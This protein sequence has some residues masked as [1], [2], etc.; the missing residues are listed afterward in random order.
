M[1]DL[2]VSFALHEAQQEIH[3]AAARFAVVVAGRRF[4]KTTYAIIRGIIEGLL[5]TNARGVALADDSE[6]LYIGTTLEQA[7]RNAWNLL[8]KY[9]D[10]VIR[11]DSAGRKMIFE[12]QS[13]V[14][15]VTGVRIRLLG[16]DNPD[17]ARGMKI[18]FAI[19]D[20]Y[21]Q[22]PETVW[23]EII[24]PALM[25]TQGGA[26]FIGTP[27]GRN[28][29]FKLFH[30]VKKGLRG[31]EWAAFNY[32]SF[33]NTFMSRKEVESAA[34]ELTRGTPHLMAQEIEAK[35][36]EP[37]GEIFNPG[38]FPI[39]EDEP[40]SG[41]YHIAVDLAGFIESREG[42]TQRD[43]SAIAVV[44]VFPL[45]GRRSNSFLSHGWWVRD[46]I[47]GQWDV[48]TTA[49]N[50]LQAAVKYQVQ[51]VGIESGALKNAVSGYLNE[52]IRDFNRPLHLEDLHHNNRSKHDR[53][54]WA[55]EGRA[56]KGRIFLAPGDWNEEFIAQACG[57]PSRLVHDDLID[58]V[59]YIDQM[60]TN[61]MYDVEALES[62]RFEPMDDASGY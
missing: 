61:T 15:L 54:R 58:A 1:S 40:T 28:H 9:A 11:L 14:V 13:Y 60:A 50:I 6:V 27:K 53:V 62:I 44:K 46:I 7:R 41:S 3:N 5:E 57:F 18:R 38:M 16:M 42:I 52:Y 2:R 25:D 36:T 51:R 55:L 43:E 20:E 22:M 49:F 47:H 39:R 12:N 48:R 17:S 19:L 32:S 24:R 8:K 31:P 29:F 10:P 33:A 59:A 26:L 4:G 34:I 37:G 21:A 23:P 30:E 35:F 56:Q 45:E